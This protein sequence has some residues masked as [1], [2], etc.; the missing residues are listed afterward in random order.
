M[1]FR[2]RYRIRK[3]REYHEPEFKQWWSPCWWTCFG[4]AICHTTQQAMDVIKRHRTRIEVI[5]ERPS[6]E[7]LDEMIEMCEEALKK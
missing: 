5:G 3:T 2:T 1:N 4:L 6:T 7:T